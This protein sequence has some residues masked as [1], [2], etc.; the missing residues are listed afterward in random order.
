VD[1]GASVSSASSSQATDGPIK[2]EE[3]LVTAQKRG[4]RLQDVPVPVSVINTESLT[5]SNQ[6]RVQDY[7]STIPGLGLSL[8][9]S[10][11]SP[12]ITIRG[13][14]TGGGTNPTVGVVIDDVPY[15]ASTAQGSGY[16]VPDLDPGDLARIEVLRGPQGALYG[17]SSIG[18]LMK[19][20]TVDPSVE[21]T[22]GRIQVGTSS[23]AGG[24]DWGYNVRGSVNLPLGETVAIRASGFKARTPGYI[25]NVQT[26]QR[27]VN[28]MDS[29]GGRLAAKWSPTDSFSLKLS[30]LVQDNQR[31]GPDTSRVQTGFADLEES[32]LAGSDTYGRK[33]QA[34]SATADA[35]LGSVDFTALSGY[36]VDRQE[37]ALDRTSVYGTFAQS[38]FGV[39]GVVAPA[40]IDTKKFSQ[41][42]RATIPLGARVK[43]LVGGFY[44]HEKTD[45]T[46]AYQA[47]ELATGGQVGAL[48]TVAIPTRYEEYAAFTDF[49]IDFTDRF[50]IQVG[51]RASRNEQSFLTT[52]GGPLAASLFRGVLLVPEVK[53]SDTPMTYLV[54][55]QLKITSDLMVYARFASGYRPGGPNTAC[56]V[57]IPCEYAADRTQ[58]YELGTKGSVLQGALTFDASLYR[59]DWKNVQLNLLDTATVTGYVANASEAKSQGVELS[60]SAHPSSSFTIAAWAAWND[61]TLTRTL[62]PS[63]GAL[64]LSG[65]RL[66]YSTRFSANLSLDEEFPL[67]ATQA[68]GFV[69]GSLSYVGDRQGIFE[70]TGTVRQDYPA[71]AQ[72]DAHLGVKYDSWVVNAFLTNATNRRGVLSG[73]TDSRFLF[74]NSFTYIQPR[75]AGI[76]IQKDF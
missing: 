36:S 72:L 46:T 42:V 43:W 53:S 48:L 11:N 27:D 50:S 73:G 45:V 29:D 6:V 74:P 7:Y 59:I 62:P 18:G 60:I 71:Y 20:V 9:G 13:V 54:T 63:A 69:G 5:N 23:I 64:G 52:R 38:I 15:G 75:T 51:G 70:P 57:N 26:G 4:E 12:T 25:D 33:T 58:N 31:K 39:G 24:D 41:E 34:Y 68:T 2:L 21:R 35:K 56:T 66:P 28:E 40:L 10:G 3:I 14:T 30:A 37:F 65:D 19:F 47:A 17:A 16:L 44:T 76:H 55:P 61:A 1:Q 32:V 22:S 67:A 8:I 49:D